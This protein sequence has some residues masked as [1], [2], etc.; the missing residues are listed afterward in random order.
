MP[1]AGCVLQAEYVPQKEHVRHTGNVPQAGH[2]QQAE[3]VLQ[4]QYVPE[5]APRAT[6]PDN[7][8][9]HF[10]SG[11]AQQHAGEDGSTHDTI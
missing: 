7:Q 1:Q 9:D 2:V 10:V 3:F 8:N 6:S 4:T 11:D 5:A